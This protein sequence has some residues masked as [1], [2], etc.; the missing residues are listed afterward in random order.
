MANP[1]AADTAKIYEQ[2]GDH[3]GGMSSYPYDPYA[4]LNPY[5]PYGNPY[6][7]PSTARPRAASAPKIPDQTGNHDGGLTS[8]PHDPLALSNRI[9]RHRDPLAD[10][11]ATDLRA[12]GA[13]K[14]KDPYGDYDRGLASTPHK[15]GALPNSHL[16]DGNLTPRVGSAPNIDNQKGVYSATGSN[17]SNARAMSNSNG[18]NPNSNLPDSLGNP[19]GATNPYSPRTQ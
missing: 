2:Y 10:P 6:G 7:R 16:G 9:E 5:G 11:F 19:Y 13:L 18:R 17:P 3:D 4:V 8:N 1:Y 14:L 15:P 12:E